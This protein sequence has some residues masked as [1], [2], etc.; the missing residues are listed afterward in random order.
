VS[1]MMCGSSRLVKA[2]A[3]INLHIPGLRNLDNP[4]VLVFP[5]VLVCLDC[6]YCGFNAAQR[7]LKGFAGAQEARAA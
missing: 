2:R 3:E 4:G 5:D 6:G 7:D 1:C